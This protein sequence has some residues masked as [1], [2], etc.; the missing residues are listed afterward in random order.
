MAG[1]G[2]KRP[3]AAFRAEANQMKN[4]LRSLLQAQKI[5]AMLNASK[6]PTLQ[7][8]LAGVAQPKARPTPPPAPPPQAAGAAQPPPVVITKTARDMMIA[9]AMVDVLK[10]LVTEEI[11]RQLDQLLGQARVALPTPQ[12]ATAPMP[13][14]TAAEPAAQPAVQPVAEPTAEP[15]VTQPAPS[16]QPPPAAAPQ[17]PVALAGETAGQN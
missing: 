11:K 8:L 5:Q 2:S 6:N 10:A 1:N 7:A 3:G 16:P 14:Q 13:A 4:G 9:Q 15:P 12:P 17:Q